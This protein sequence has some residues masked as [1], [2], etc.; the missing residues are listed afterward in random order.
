MCT[1]VVMF[2]AALSLLSP[3]AGEPG[4]IK[5]LIVTGYNHPAHNWK[6]T[7]L[8]LQ[9]IYRADPRFDV[10]VVEDPAFL[11][12]PALAA[13]DVVILN[14]AD[15]E[16]PSP[17]DKARAN[18]QQVIESGKGL[19]VLHFASGAWDES[20]D[21]VKLAGRIWKKDVSG[22]DAKGPFRV[23]VLKTENPIVKGLESFD[24]DDELYYSLEGDQP[25]EVLATAK[26]KITG[27]DEPMAFIFPLNK[28]RVFHMTLGHDS[29]ALHVPVGAELLRRG[30]AWAAGQPAAPEA[31]APA[32]AQQQSEPATAGS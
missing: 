26:S 14:F 24:T 22:H 18:L 6:D 13:Y 28:G 15:Y 10:R 12:S 23:E 3:A 8:A 29:Q 5:T 20:P 17:G 30:T 21:F 16:R 4:S 9:D 11:E 19:V 1:S 32:Q 2:A 25:I 27:K 31:E 7:T